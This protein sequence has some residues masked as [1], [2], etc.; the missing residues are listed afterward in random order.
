MAPPSMTIAMAHA[1][2]GIVPWFAD[3]VNNLVASILPQEA[4][5]SYKDKIKGDDKYYVWDDPYLWK[6]CNDQVIRRFIP[7]HETYTCRFGVPKALI[8][9]Q[10]SHC[11]NKT[12]STLL[13]KYGVVHR[14]AT[15]YHPQTNGQVDVFNREIKQILQKGSTTIEKIRFGC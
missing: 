9:D 5:K 8:N 12:M 15:N 6:F 7:D 3:I 13:E 14:V 11:C 1:L 2:D 10:G 4:S